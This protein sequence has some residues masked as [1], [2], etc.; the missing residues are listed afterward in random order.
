MSSAHPS[1]VACRVANHPSAPRSDKFSAMPAIDPRDSGQ[2]KNR[3][4]YLGSPSVVRTGFI[5]DDQ[6]LRTALSPRQRRRGVGKIPVA[7]KRAIPR[8]SRGNRGHR[9]QFDW[10][11]CTLICHHH[12]SVFAWPCVC[13]AKRHSLSRSCNLPDHL[14]VTSTTA[15]ARHKAQ[16]LRRKI[17]LRRT[18]ERSGGKHSNSRLKARVRSCGA[19]RRQLRAPS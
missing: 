1:R 17:G 13:Q 5:G 10:W 8:V 15:T 7:I 16:V 18:L 9:S 6:L 19:W 12:C 14:A 11:V 2:T 4:M 3:D